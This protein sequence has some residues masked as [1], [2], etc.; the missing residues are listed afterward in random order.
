M[1]DFYWIG[2]QA[3]AATDFGETNNDGVWVP[4]QYAGSFGTNGFYL[5]GQDS[6]DLGND[7]SGNS[8]NFTSSGLTSDDQR[9]DT[10]TN[11]L[12]TFNPLNNMRDDG[13]PTDGN[14]VFYNT[15]STRICPSIFI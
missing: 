6:A 14:R 2:D 7:S 13:D 9:V 10:P 15:G 4:K 3:L 8:N 5:K 11:N 12:M 1:A